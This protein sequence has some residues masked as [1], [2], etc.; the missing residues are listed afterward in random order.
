MSDAT[1]VIEIEPGPAEPPPLPKKRSDAPLPL[2]VAKVPAASWPPK[3][4]GDLMTRKVVTVAEDDPVGD[5]E[6]WMQRFR[7]RHLPVVSTE[8]KLVG[9][10]TRTDFLH[11][12][13]GEQNDGKPARRVNENTPASAIMN[14]NVVTAQVDSPL[15]TA[16]RVMLHEKLGCLPV[17]KDDKT[18]VGI[19]TATDFSRLA[20]EL[21]APT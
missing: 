9:L 14:R 5:L 6:A 20:L 13:L 4:V 8:M 2:S 19:V 16:L 7:F 12:A 17:V 11:A 18:L 10:I 3:T 15:T 1:E 21:L